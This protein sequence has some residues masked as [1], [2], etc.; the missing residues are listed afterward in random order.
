MVKLS[1]SRGG[2]V[3]KLN[4]A[5][6]AEERFS[7]QRLP[8]GGT[9]PFQNCSSIACRRMRGFLSAQP[10]Y[11][12]GP[13]WSLASRSGSV[14]ERKLLQGLEVLDLN[15]SSSGKRAL[16]M[17]DLCLIQRGRSARFLMMQIV[18]CYLGEFGMYLLMTNWPFSVI[19]WLTHYLL[20][21]FN[22]RN[23]NTK[24]CKLCLNELKYTSI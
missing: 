22:L 18:L 13:L 7:G 1:S 6:R 4:T 16:P 21:A 9:E 15:K 20:C 14:F 5:H 2:E 17:G 23:K 19:W 3:L 11:S 24:S 8:W 12:Q 10:T